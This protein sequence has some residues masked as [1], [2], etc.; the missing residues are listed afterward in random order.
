MRHGFSAEIV[1]I[2]LLGGSLATAGC[3]T[4]SVGAAVGAKDAQPAELGRIRAAVEKALVAEPPRGYAAVPK[5]VRLL[6]VER[7][8][9]A[10]VLDFS[11][12][13][14]AGGTGRVLEDAIHQ[15]VVAAS[16]ARGGADG[17]AEDYRVLIDG[18]GV[19]A[20]LR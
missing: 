6:S 4:R 9:R 8:D 3:A 11:G 19:D 12:E 5:G 18:V 16:A 13:L 20:Y 2:A 17:R 15:I 14:L 1:T 10:V 7:D